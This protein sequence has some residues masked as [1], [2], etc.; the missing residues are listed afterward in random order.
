MIDDP[1]FDRILDFIEKNDI[2]VI[3]HLGEPKNCWLPVDQMTIAGDKNYFTANPGYHMYLHPEFPSYE[4]Q[5]NARD[6]MLRKHP[7]LRFVGAHLGSLEW[8]VD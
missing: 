3:G 7:G 5:I 2:T 4:A 6:N 1:R 8:N